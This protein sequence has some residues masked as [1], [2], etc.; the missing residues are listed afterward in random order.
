MKKWVRTIFLGICLFAG[1]PAF[2][3]DSVT[4]DFSPR[5][6]NFPIGEPFPVVVLLNTGGAMINAVEGRIEFDKDTLEVID[7]AK[8]E[9]IIKLW[10]T[11]P[12]VSNKDGT[13][14]F[15]GGMLG[16]F[17]GQNG[18][19][20]TIA[21]RAKRQDAGNIRFAT[22]AALAADGLGSNILSKMYGGSYMFS[23]DNAGGN[24]SY[25][26]VAPS[27]FITN[28]NYDIE[29]PILGAES[30]GPLAL[31][32]K[33]HPDPE[34]WYAKKDGDITWGRRRDALTLQFSIDQDKDGTP[35]T[36]YDPALTAKHFK[37]VGDGL[38]YA[39]LTIGSET[40]HDE[41]GTF[42]FRIDSTKPSAFNIL[43]VP[44][45]D[46]FAF[47][48]EAVDETSG[49]DRYEITI[50]SLDK[51][52]FKD[53]GTHVF[54][55]GNFTAGPHMMQVS[56][57]DKAGNSLERSINFSVPFLD[58]P[59]ISRAP[60]SIAAGGELE[61]EGIATP[62]ASVRV[63]VDLDHQQL[64]VEKISTDEE[65][66]FV[67]IM[68]G[69]KTEDYGEYTLS[70]QTVERGAKSEAAVVTVK[71]TA[72]FLKKVFQGIVSGMKAVAPVVAIAIPP[73]GFLLYVLRRKP[74]P[75]LSSDTSYEEA[76]FSSEQETGEVS[77]EA[78]EP[79]EDSS[80]QHF[81]KR[82]VRESGSVVTLPK[83]KNI[84]IKKD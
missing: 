63:T 46:E 27:T 18:R 9:S 79:R 36:F 40:G 73:A 64:F 58:A 69:E 82:Q 54:H 10:T 76:M 17:S 38:W 4:L 51:R 21:F 59:S 48:F 37:N 68:S 15:G 42:P 52:T 35:T 74:K 34:L 49:I 77:E 23:A 26:E 71:A 72:S 78:R 83:W 13:V 65:G 66:K 81:Y 28:S 19:L 30:S 53:D 16:G 6:G 61:I 75:A 32:S 2:A 1:I 7:I 8:N 22:A 11:D 25:T 29:A 3:D 60:E 12:L 84:R 70:F 45:D 31:S 44:T 50:D 5:T 56:A 39:H 14:I 33:S 41:S 67:F 20:F 24:I 47:Q 55:A 57:F 43:E 62:E 80:Y